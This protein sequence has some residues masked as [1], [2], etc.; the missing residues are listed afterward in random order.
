MKAQGD[1]V[2]RRI[3]AGRGRGVHGS[4]SSRVRIAVVGVLIRVEQ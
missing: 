2:E 4:V 1:D 3:G